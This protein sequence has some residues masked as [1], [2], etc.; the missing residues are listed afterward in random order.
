MSGRRVTWSHRVGFGLFRLAAAAIDAAPT[1]LVVRGC[2]VLAWAVNALPGKWTRGAVVRENL[3]IAYPHLTPREADAVALGMWT[4]LLRL[5]CEMVQVPRKVRRENQADVLSF[6]NRDETVRA[7]N[8]GRP[9]IVLGGHFGNW[10]IAA[11]AFGAMGVPVSMVARDLD[12]PLLHD[13][14]AARR[15][16][17]GGRLISKK[18]GGGAVTDVLAAGGAVGLLADQSAGSNGLFVPFFGRDASTF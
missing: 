7:V 15:E 3:R 13:W 1:P 8:S 14:F 12:N 10:E 2:W 5:I 17:S 11:T 16:A 6:V 18:G 9:L 4:H